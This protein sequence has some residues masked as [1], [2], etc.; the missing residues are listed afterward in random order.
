MRTNPEKDVKMGSIRRLEIAQI[1]PQPVDIM[2]IDFHQK[3]Y[4]MSFC[5]D[6]S[7]LALSI[8]KVGLIDTPLLMDTGDRKQIVSGYRRISALKSLGWD[9]VP[10]RILSVSQISPLD[11][12]LLSFYENISFR[13]FNAVEKGMV[14][15]RLSSYIEA[16][17]ILTHYM[18]LLDLPSRL[19]TFYFYCRLDQ[20][21]DPEIKEALIKGTLSLQTIKYLFEISEDA[22]AQV[23]TLFLNVTFNMNQQRHLIE[24]LNDISHSENI[25]ISNI[26]KEETLKTIISNTQMNNPQ[27]ASAALNAL[28]SRIYPQ[29]SSAEQ[30]FKKTVSNLDL[31]ERTRLYHSPFFES[32]DY[33]MEVLFQDGK[34]LKRKI[35][36]LSKMKG[37]LNLNDPWES[38]S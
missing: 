38:N 4:C 8:K 36:K 33:R 34:D 28:R 21:P 11:C 26:L 7:L 24:Y 13:T 14:L 9:T 31:P 1:K 23:L 35:E 19:S 22:R 10:C 20:E 18:P 5:F 16:E 25:S 30:F 15:N 29:L 12:L 17:E 27:K 3:P 2:D 32:P 37:L 6:V